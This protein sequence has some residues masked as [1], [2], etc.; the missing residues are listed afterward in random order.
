[1]NVMETTTVRTP[2]FG[3]KTSPANVGYHDILRVWQEADEIPEI[4]HAWLYDHLLPN[5]GGR[6]G[7]PAGPILEGWTLLAALAART[8]RLRL[9]VLV[10]NNRIRRPAVL[11]KIAATVDVISNGRLDFGIGVGGLPEAELIA[12]EYDAFGIPIGRWRDAV[13]AFAESCTIIRRMW[14]EE[15]F[16]FA[17]EHHQLTGARCNPKPIQRPHPPIVIAGTG[18][19]TLRIAAEHA[20]VWNVIGPPANDVEHLAQRSAALDEQCAAIG[21]DPLTI[22]RSVQLPVSYGDPSGIRSTMRELVEVGFTHVVLN[23]PTPYPPHVAQWVADEL[24]KPTRGD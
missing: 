15:V 2:S 20:D 14:T 12:P 6:V 5:I 13:A 7:D 23:L 24:I 10:T 8:H 1:M 22:T 3:I 21:R 16:D 4:E 19:A 11:A 9:G 18:E 17:G